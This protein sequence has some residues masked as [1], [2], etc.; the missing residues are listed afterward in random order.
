MSADLSKRAVAGL[1]AALK[2][3][4][5]TPAAVAKLDYI[6]ILVQPGIGTKTM[7]E[8]EVWLARHGLNF[9]R[10]RRPPAEILRE[11]QAQDSAASGSHS[12]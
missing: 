11:M 8:I 9:Q 6:K 7:N 1:Q 3:R 2:K 4:K 10:P 5:V 12:S